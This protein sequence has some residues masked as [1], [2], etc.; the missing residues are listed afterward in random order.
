MQFKNLEKQKQPKP[1]SSR[2]QDVIKKTEQK[3]F[4]GNNENNSESQ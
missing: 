4:F 3:L 1:K 2:W